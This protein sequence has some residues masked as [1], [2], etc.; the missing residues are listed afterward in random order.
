MGAVIPTEKNQVLKIFMDVSHYFG[1]LDN[2]F[3]YINDEYTVGQKKK[4]KT[5][6]FILIQ[7]IVQK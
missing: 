6:L 7:I 1:G 3:C 4:K 5:P 2:N